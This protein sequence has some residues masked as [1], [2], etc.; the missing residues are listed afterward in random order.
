LD[1]TIVTAL[2]IIAGVVSVV[3]VF[4]TIYPAVLQSG[5]AIVG[6]GKR[7]DEHLQSQIEIV[8]AV[9]YGDVTKVVYVWVKNVGSLSIGAVEQ[10]D[11]FF[12]PEGNFTRIPY[13]EGASHWTYT[14]ENGTNWTST[15][16]VKITIDYQ[17]YLV[18]GQRYFVKVVLPNGV[19]DEYCFSK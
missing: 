5:N 4:N 3:L 7:I 19:S 18:N 13:G 6:R 1:K 11:V 15:A 14:V 8:H 17:D 9:A 10:C 12:G 2:L 16:T